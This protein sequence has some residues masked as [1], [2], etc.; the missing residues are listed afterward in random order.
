MVAI[1]II[2]WLDNA[3]IFDNTI[4][5][6][7]V[8]ADWSSMFKYI[9]TSLS[10]QSE[11]LTTS[12]VVGNHLVELSSSSIDFILM[13]FANMQGYVI[14]YMAVIAV[15]LLFGHFYSKVNSV[16]L[17]DRVTKIVQRF[18][19][20][21]VLY[22]SVYLLIRFIFVTFTVTELTTNVGLRFNLTA[23]ESYLRN[24]QTY[25]NHAMSLIFLIVLAGIHMFIS[26]LMTASAQVSPEVPIM[27]YLVA[28]FAWSLLELEDFALFLVCLEGFSLTLYILATVGRLYGGISAAIKYFVFGT[29]GSILLYWGGVSIFELTANM[30]ISSISD[31]LN[32]AVEN[33]T[34][35]YDVY[36]KAVLAQV[37]ILI[38]FLIKLGAAPLHQ[39]IA[40]VYAGVPLFVTAFYSIFVKLVLFILFL[41]FALSFASAK[42]IE[43]AALLSLIVGCFG[44][45]RQVEIKRFLAYGSI[46]HT[47]YLLMGDLNATYVYLATYVLASFIFFSVLL[48]IKLNGQEFIYLSDLRF[49]GQSSNLL[50]RT[51]LVVVLASM[52]GLPPFAGFYGKMLVWTSLIEDIY[53]FN[54]TWSFILLLANL[55]TS[56]IMM[57][58]YMQVMCTLYVNDEEEKENVVSSDVRLPENII[59]SNS[60]TTLQYIGLFLLT[61]WTFVIPQFLSTL[62]NLI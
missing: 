24:E 43:F 2:T 56:L 10:Y 29:L 42:E 30:N 54:D 9:A 3:F 33:S 13:V 60:I 52:A 35:N 22:Y 34:S 27:T 36:S 45:L 23:I 26:S 16:T 50:D 46:A 49:V 28:C 38:G 1:N 12:Y 5:L 25:Y 14:N 53:M 31:L 11:S 20:L 8:T 41:K 62:N 15:T 51:I 48:N 32:N 6:F 39:W 7:F 61:L 58:Y 57:F 44:T 59:N 55:L 37:F 17:L 18:W 19:L 40:D 21:N 47:G 4:P